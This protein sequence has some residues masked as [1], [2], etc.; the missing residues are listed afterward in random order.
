[1]PGSHAKLSPSASSIWMN[2][3]GMPTLAE[4]YEKRSS[5]V[6]ADRGTRA[7][8][9]L[10]LCLTGGREAAEFIGED[11]ADL[12][13]LPKPF[14]DEDA[15]AVQIAVD[16]I[17]D[18]IAPGDEWETEVQ[19][20]YNDDFWGTCDFERFRPSDGELLVV[21][22]KHGV[23]P[24]D[25]Y[26]NPQGVSYALMKVK[27][28]GNRGISSVRFVIVQPRSPYDGGPVKEF[29]IDGLDMLDWE[30]RINAAIA[31]IAEAANYRKMIALPLERSTWPK[32]YLNRGKWCRWC[33]ANFAGG[34]PLVTAEIQTAA[35]LDFSAA[36]KG[37]D[38]KELSDAL[39][40]A[41]RAE[42][43]IKA[44]RQFAYQEADNGVSIPEWKLVDK[45]PTERWRN[46]DGAA[47][48]ADL[49]G[50]D[51]GDIY[52]PRAIK[53]PAQI[54]TAIEPAM[55]GATKKART[56]AAKAALSEHIEKV[57]SGTTLAPESDPRPV[58]KRGATSDFDP[59]LD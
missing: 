46:A 7:H 21:D 8:K 16:F 51:D 59:I 34:C 18:Q 45:R 25:A 33:P 1:M 10:E 9:V 3:A 47:S 52:E 58:A 57:S 19:L 31:K 11:F 40:L 56:E 50:L 17:R 41:D 43:A 39:K 44:T 27:S 35:T 15:G 2:C 4:Q 32:V 55:D 20:R 26:E 6:D 53:S 37:Y 13:T 49:L 38:P 22:Y 48:L 28:L 29:V 30:D 42:A 24:V 14:N 5:S 12:V 23:N 36:E 54:R